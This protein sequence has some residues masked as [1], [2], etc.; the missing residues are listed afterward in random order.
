MALYGLFTTRTALYVNLFKYLITYSMQLQNFKYNMNTQLI[1]QIKL[2]TN[3]NEPRRLSKRNNQ[4]NTKQIP[5]LS[6]KGTTEM[7]ILV[8]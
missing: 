6:Y 7:Q 8:L 2:Q 5:N 3:Y 1:L 4:H